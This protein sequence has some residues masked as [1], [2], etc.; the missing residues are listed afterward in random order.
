MMV[1]C[2]L[3]RGAVCGRPMIRTPNVFDSA[4]HQARWATV[5]YIRN[6]DT[7]YI[8]HCLTTCGCCRSLHTA[9]QGALAWW[10]PVPWQPDRW[11]VSFTLRRKS[12]LLKYT[13]TVASSSIHHCSS[14]NGSASFSRITK[15]NLSSSRGSP[16]C[17]NL[18]ATASR[19]NSTLTP[20]APP[21]SLVPRANKL[22]SRDHAIPL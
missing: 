21:P 11:T 10:T 7:P 15:N 14:P 1:L 5:P 17:R 2:Q 8:S 22:A 4:R 13:L 20:P 19:H 6:F 9:W 12:V 3:C 16:P 18:T